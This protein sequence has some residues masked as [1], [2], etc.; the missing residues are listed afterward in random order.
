MDRL[1]KKK[2]GYYWGSLDWVL[3]ETIINFRALRM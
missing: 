3:S 2:E 1:Q